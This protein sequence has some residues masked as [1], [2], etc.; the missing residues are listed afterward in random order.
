MNPSIWRRFERLEQE[1]CSSPVVGEYRILCREV[2]Q[3]SGQ[4]RVRVTLVD[5]GLLEV[6]EYVMAGL[7]GVLIVS[8]YRYHWQD[9]DGGIVRRWDS[10]AHHSGLPD[11]PHHVHFPDGRIEGVTPAPDITTVLTEIEENLKKE[12]LTDA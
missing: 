10:A 9:R 8:K 4:I 11:A 5:G 6:F 2:A 1:L 7:N 3:P 12:T